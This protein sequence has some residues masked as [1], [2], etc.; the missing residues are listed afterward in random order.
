METELQWGPPEFI[1]YMKINL[2]KD[3]DGTNF[4]MQMDVKKAGG[5][6]K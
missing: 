6:T 2:I 1:K 3:Y 4:V 5:P